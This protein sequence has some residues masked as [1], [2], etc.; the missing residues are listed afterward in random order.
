ML[1][2]LPLMLLYSPLHML[3]DFLY[4]LTHVAKHAAPLKRGAWL[5]KEAADQGAPGAPSPPSSGLVMG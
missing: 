5:I 4:V 1:S 2:S 3:M